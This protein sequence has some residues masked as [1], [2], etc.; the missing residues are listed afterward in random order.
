MPSLIVVPSGIGL[1][2]SQ[3]TSAHCLLPSTSTLP[4]IGADASSIAGC[5]CGAWLLSGL[6]G[7]GAGSPVSSGVVST[8]GVGVP[9]S[10][11]SE[12][13]ASSTATIAIPTVSS[14]MSTTPSNRMTLRAD[15]DNLLFTLRCDNCQSR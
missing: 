12:H 15:V 10:F 5:C 7:S 6:V 2:P 11:V 8:P 4:P 13:P 14:R 3:L 9:P 1:R